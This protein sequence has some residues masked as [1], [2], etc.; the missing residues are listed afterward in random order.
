MMTAYREVP[1]MWGTSDRRCRAGVSGALGSPAPVDGGEVRDKPSGVHRV[2][3]VL[4][5]VVVAVVLPA[6]L[7][8]ALVG[9]LGVLALL[10]GV[11]LGVA[12]SK[13]GGTYRMV[14]VAPML[15]VAAG[16]G[17]FTAYDWWWAALVASAGVVTGAGFGFGWFGALLMV[18]FAATF[19]PP[20]SSGTDAVI[21]GVIVRSRPSTASS[22]PAGSAHPRSSRGTACPRQSPRA[23]RWCLASSWVAPLR[24]VSHWDGPSRTGFRSRFLYWRS[25]S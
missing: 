22:S 3:H 10:V 12:G 18:P 7:M 8:G 9:W 25:T 15:G 1:S 19:V 14:F 20:V 5:A 4:G 17:A 11:I 2:L 6:L 24:L 13:L 16:L 23:W 21:Y